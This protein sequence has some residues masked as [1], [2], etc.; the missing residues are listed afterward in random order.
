MISKINGRTARKILYGVFALGSAAGLS[1]ALPELVSV[2]S[3]S[4]TDVGLGE[5]VAGVVVDGLTLGACVLGF[6]IDTGEAVAAAEV[7][8]KAAGIPTASAMDVSAL[9]V[10]VL[11][12]SG[13]RRPAVVGELQAEAQRSIIVLA[14]PG[15]WVKECVKSARFVSEV[16]TSGDVLIVPVPLDG[17]AAGA[18]DAK[19]FGAGSAWTDAPFVALPAAADDSPASVTDL[20][21]F[22]THFKFDLD[23]ANDATAAVAAL[24]SLGSTLS[25]D[26]S[27]T[28]AEVWQEVQ[29][30]AKADH[31]AAKAVV[32]DARAQAGTDVTMGEKAVRLALKKGEAFSREDSKP[33]KYQLHE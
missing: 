11:T 29:K 12:E 25:E 19:G 14:G 23:V 18:G 33:P 22:A 4:S 10:E 3:G 30:L 31:A 15:A 8:A 13:K 32:A 26:K 28:A 2:A 7:E 27:S 20:V 5:A 16:F 9:G 17:A 1:T 24:R 6:K 21:F